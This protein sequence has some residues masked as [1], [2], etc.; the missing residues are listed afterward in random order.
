MFAAYNITC[1]LLPQR[2][3][4]LRDTC[5]VTPQQYFMFLDRMR[6]SEGG[7]ICRAFGGGLALPTSAEEQDVRYGMLK[8]ALLV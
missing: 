7:Q 3:I 8:H 6:F 4:P 2:R 1:G 5:E